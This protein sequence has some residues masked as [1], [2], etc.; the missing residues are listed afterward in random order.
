M[1]IILEYKDT[2]T[3]LNILK[4][5]AYRGEC[6]NDPLYGKLNDKMNCI[7]IEPVERYIKDLKEYH[8][9][10]LPMN[11]FIYINKALGG[12]EGK[13]QIHYPSVT[14][15][16]N[17]LPLWLEQCASSRPDHVKSHGYEI[18]MDTAIVP[19]T[20]I[21][22][23][24]NYYFV[25]SIDWLCCDTEGMDYDILMAYDFSVKPTF[26]SFEKIHMDGYKTVG[27]KYDT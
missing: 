26:L 1:N 8:G 16:W 19:M 6:G 18:D 17:T 9:K 15:D 11:H 4:I 24:L 27:K 23:I 14:N 12:Q 20:T 7:F 2:F 25:K 22:T 10:T 13:I 21:K 5:G 3:H